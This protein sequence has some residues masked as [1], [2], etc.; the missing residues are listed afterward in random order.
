MCSIGAGPATCDPGQV[1]AA[2][3]SARCGRRAP[4]CATRSADGRAVRVGWPAV[5]VADTALAD[6]MPRLVVGEAAGDGAPGDGRQYPTAAPRRALAGRH[7]RGPARRSPR[8]EQA[9]TRQTL[10]QPRRREP[11]GRTTCSAS[12]DTC[13]LRTL[14]GSAVAAR[15]ES[16]TE[17][18]LR[19][20]TLTSEPPRST[21]RTSA[22]FVSTAVSGVCGCS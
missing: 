18:Y 9:C 3:H 5:R 16:K 11:P 15:P 22:D 8:C 10:Q 7:E 6:S 21:G 19:L 12:A 20:E 1:T 17:A 13:S 2:I 4:M 14:R